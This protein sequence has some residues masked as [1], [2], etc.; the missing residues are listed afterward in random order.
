MPRTFI[1][2]GFLVLTMSLVVVACGKAETPE[3]MEPPAEEAVTESAGATAAPAPAEEEAELPLIVT[4]ANNVTGVGSYVAGEAFAIASKAEAEEGQEPEVIVEAIIIPYG[5]YPDKHVTD[6]A[7]FVGP[8]SVAEGFTFDWDLAAPDG[9]AAELVVSGGVATFMA[10]VGGD[11]ELALTATSAEGISGSTT[12][13]VHAANYVGVGGI[14]G[15]PTTGQCAGCH[16]DKAEAWAGTGHATMLAEGI[17]GIKSDHYGETCIR[18]HTVGFDERPEA[19][20]G[21]FDD[22]AAETGWEFPA[23]LQEG[24]WEAMKA[25][26]P[27]AAGLA[28][29]QCESCHGP[30]SDHMGTGPI[31]VSLAY[32]TCAQCHAEQTH[33][34]YPM[35]WELSGHANKSGGLAYAGAVNRDS[36][37]KCHSGVG[38]IDTAEGEEEIGTGFQLITCAVC[39]D[40][41]DAT[42]EHQLRVYDTTVALADGTE[43]TGAG[44]AATCMTC[45][46]S[47]RDASLVEGEE[48]L[49]LP[50]YS[51][52]AELMLNTGGYTWGETIDDSPHGVMVEGTCVGCHMAETPGMDDMG[53]PDD[54]SDDKPLPGHNT[55]G[56]HTFQV[57]SPVDGTQNVAVCQ[58]C[59][60]NVEAFEFDAK[61]DHDGD[62]AV[63]SNQAEIEGLREQL[64]DAFIAEGVV[65]LGHHPYFELPE[66]ASVD[67]RGAVWNYKFTGSGGSAVHN[68]RHTLRLL[69]LSLDKLAGE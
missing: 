26:S 63:E 22:V 30:G 23:E 8:E 69:Q 32:G 49:S 11:Y 6:I 19:A 44:A 18:C 20:N 4:T 2:F 7:D 45:H 51:T 61:E 5:I 40:P 14:A 55:V 3:P 35:Q 46:Q 52:A 31:G 37:T 17:D 43:I 13:A 58:Q 16:A 47:R 9:S 60:P 65:D 28:N 67:L 64:Y 62:G 39:H 12:W 24:N 59:H 38:Y 36:C 68:F 53:T 48:A 25:D 27:E 1:L 56:A 42:N 50:H 21:G 10:D 33:H 41:H 66:G 15:D 57:V 29:I 34:V 54:A